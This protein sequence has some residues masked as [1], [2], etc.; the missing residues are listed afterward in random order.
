MVKHNDVV[1]RNENFF[2]VKKSKD[3]HYYL[4]LL[5]GNATV[6]AW[7]RTPLYKIKALYEVVENYDGNTVKMFDI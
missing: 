1:K 5:L 2:K 7:H 6:T 3:G 4:S